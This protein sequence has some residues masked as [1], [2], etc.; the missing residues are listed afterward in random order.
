MDKIITF[1]YEY[2]I[3]DLLQNGVEDKLHPVHTNTIILTRH[4]SEL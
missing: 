4:C 1:K 2:T 3:C